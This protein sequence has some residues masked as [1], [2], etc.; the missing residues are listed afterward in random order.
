MN[1][2]VN[3]READD[4][5]RHRAHYDVTVMFFDRAFHRLWEYRYMGHWAVNKYVSGKEG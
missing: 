1:G 3:K 4:L 5:L 2:W